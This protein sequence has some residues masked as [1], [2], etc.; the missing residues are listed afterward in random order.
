MIASFT[1]LVTFNLHT[2]AAVAKSSQGGSCEDN[3]SNYLL[4]GRW[5]ECHVI[6]SSSTTVALFLMQGF[7]LNFLVDYSVLRCSL[8]KLAQLC[9][10]SIFTR[11]L[12]PVDQWL[13]SP[14]AAMT[15]Y[16]N[17]F[18]NHTPFAVSSN[19]Q[20]NRY[21]SIISQLLNQ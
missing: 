1:S 15:I 16:T 13:N 2:L 9:E 3:C 14:Q 5:S 12:S 10:F 7:L 6:R 11:I 4:L 17:L 21:F 20:E 19:L 8:I 18:R